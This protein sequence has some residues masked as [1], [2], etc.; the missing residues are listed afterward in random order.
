MTTIENWSV[1]RDNSDLNVP[2]ER[3]PGLLHGEVYAHPYKKDGTH[4]TTSAIVA[5]NLIDRTC[6]TRSSRYRLGK[7]HADYE[8]R[9]PETKLELA[10][11]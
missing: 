7:P 9:H 6:V 5:L 3:R 8:K 2:P 1:V 4:V 10:P 11:V